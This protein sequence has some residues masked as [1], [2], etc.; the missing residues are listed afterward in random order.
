MYI[1]VPKYE[2]RRMSIL[3]Y[4]LKPTSLK[5]V[6]SNCFYMRAFDFHPSIVDKSSVLIS[7]LVADYYQNCDMDLILLL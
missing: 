3:A 5:L 2:Y 6:V 1:L 7:R 4:D